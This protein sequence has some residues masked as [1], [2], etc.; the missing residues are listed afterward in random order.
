M[1]QKKA[2]TTSSEMPET[3]QMEEINPEIEQSDSEELGEEALKNGTKA[4][5][6]LHHNGRP[7]LPYVISFAVLAAL[8]LLVALAE[9]GYTPTET[10]L[11]LGKWGSSVA[12]SGVFGLSIGLLVWASNG[13][14][15]DIFA[16][17]GRIFVRMFFKKDVLDRKYPT[18]YDYR[19]SRKGKKRSYW[20]L[21]IVGAVFLVV[22][23]ILLV[24]G[25]QLMPQK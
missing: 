2:N 16:Y 14:A 1:K 20:Y 3:A 24:I 11:M 22:G 12:I 19:E 23:I 21:V 18:Y 9:G 8:T 7:W 15:F 13:G 17:G 4:L 6:A 25:N 10:W 5:N